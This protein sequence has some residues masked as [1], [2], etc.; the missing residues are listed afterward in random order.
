MVEIT[1]GDYTGYYYEEDGE[2]TDEQ[3]EEFK[4][5]QNNG[6]K[7][8]ITVEVTSDKEDNEIRKIKKVKVL[9]E[10]AEE[11]EDSNGQEVEGDRKGK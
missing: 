6:L 7:V 1:D 11:N 10:G 2:F 9:G 5:A 8:K 3:L 4:R